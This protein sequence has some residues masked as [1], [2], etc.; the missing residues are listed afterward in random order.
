MPVHLEELD[1]MPKVKGLNSTLIVACN[2]CAGASF[3]MKEN[4]PFIQFFSNFLTSPPLARHITRLQSQLNKIGLKT[5]WF[6]DGIIQKFFLCLWTSRQ[7]RKFRQYAD[8]YDGVIVLGCDSAFKTI[9]DSV[10]GTDCKVIEGTKVRGIMNT[11]TKLHF[12]CNISFEGSKVAT[13]CD[14]HCKQFR[15][16]SLN[17][18]AEDIPV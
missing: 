12:P 14:L 3:A 8:K 7:R 5:K 16:Q 9:R 4:R 1:V 15:Q 10:Q 18:K 13:M 11:K 6:K 2:M 17:K